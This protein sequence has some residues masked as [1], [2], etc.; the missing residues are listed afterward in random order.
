M[1]ESNKHVAEQLKLE[2]KEPCKVMLGS[3]LEVREMVNDK[4][5]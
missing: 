4:K 3:N 2:E 1:K 5:N